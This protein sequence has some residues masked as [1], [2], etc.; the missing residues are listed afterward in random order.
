MCPIAHLLQLVICCKFF[1]IKIEIMSVTSAAISGT[2]S[3]IADVWT[4]DLVP[5]YLSHQV[6]ERWE[7][8]FMRLS[9]EIL[10]E[11]KFC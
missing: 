5:Q 7:W 8:C 2:V 10:S 6:K 9:R 4:Q 3:L 11:F 1:K